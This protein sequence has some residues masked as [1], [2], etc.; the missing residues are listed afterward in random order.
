MSWREEAAQ[1]VANAAKSE[2]TKPT[3]APFGGFG[4]SPQAAI[5]PEAWDYTVADLSEMEVMIRQLAELEDWSPAELEGAL[6]QRRRM[7]PIRV[8]EALGELR[9]AVERS[10][11]PWPE[12]PA[13]RSRIVLC[14]L[15]A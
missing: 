4:S 3:K 11:G 6:D 1:A 9:E 13:K 5:S 12:K 2:P 8:P 10:L 15:T 14:R 7:A